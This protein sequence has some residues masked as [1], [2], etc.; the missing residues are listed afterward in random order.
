MMKHK[1]LQPFAFILALWLLLSSMPVSA[2]AELLELETQPMGDQTVYVLAEDTTKRSEFEKHYYC[3]DGTFVA[4]TY[5]EAVHYK[6]DNGEWIDVDMR[7]AS[8]ASAA[9]YEGQSGDFKTVFS[10]PCTGGD[11][12]VMA[13]GVSAVTPAVSM[14][15]GEYTLSWSLTGT[16]AAASAGTSTYALNPAA[17]GGETI[18]SASADTQIQV[19]GEMKTAEPAL[20]VQKIP[21]TDPDAFAL[22]SASN[23][24]LYENIFGEDQ[25][26]S[27][28]YSVTQNRIEED[29]L[30]TAPTDM[31]S[32]SMQVECTGL[33]PVLNLD[34]SVDF[35]DNNGEMV[36]HVS[37]PYLADAAFSVSYDVQVTL[38]EQDGVCTITYTPDAEWMN[39]PEREYPIMLDPAVTTQNY[40]YAISDTH[41]VEGD[42]TWYYT[43]QYLDINQSA[44]VRKA[45]IFRFNDLPQIEPG[46]PIHSATFKLSSYTTLSPI[47]LKLDSLIQG[48]DMLMDN[49]DDWNMMLKNRI[50]TVTFP[51]GTSTFTFDISTCITDMYDGVIGREFSVALADPYSTSYVAPIFS[52]DSNWGNS[53]KPCLIIEYGYELTDNLLVGDDILIQNASSDGYLCPN[54]GLIGDGNLVLHAPATI[55]SQNRRFTLKHNTVTGGYQFEYNLYT[56]NSGVCVSADALTNYVQM[57][58][59]TNVPTNV[60]REWLIIPVGTS[61]FKIALAS[62]TRYVMT[63]VGEKTDYIA[64]PDSATGGYVSI[65]KCTGTPTEAQLWHI[66]KNGSLVYNHAKEILVDNGTYYLN[67]DDTGMFLRSSGSQ[68]DTTRGRVDGLGI[69]IAWRITWINGDFYILQNP[70][71]TTQALT[72]NRLGGVSMTP[73]GTT[74]SD[75]QKWIFSKTAY[76][77]VLI[78]EGT[79]RTLKIG[80]GTDDWDLVKCTEYVEL[81]ANIA[82]EDHIIALGETGTANTAQPIPNNTTYAL[83]NKNFTYTSLNPNVVIVDQNTG[84]FQGVNRGTAQ[85]TAMHEVTGITKT[86]NVTVEKKAIIIVPGFAGSVLQMGNLHPYYPVVSRYNNNNLNN[87]KSMDVFSMQRLI[88][89]GN[90]GEEAKVAFKEI[91]SLLENIST[92]YDVEA[93]INQYVD[94]DSTQMYIDAIESMVLLTTLKMFHD[95]NFS[96]HLNPKP[97]NLLE[98]EDSMDKYGVGNVYKDLYGELKRITETNEE[99]RYYEVTLFTYDWRQSCANSAN[100]LN[101]FIETNA[102]DNVILVCHS[103]GGLVGDGYLSIGE[104]QREKVEKY[105]TFGTPH[106]GTTLT[107]AVCLTG[108]VDAFI[109]GP[110]DENGNQ[111]FWLNLGDYLLKQTLVRWLVAK[112]PSIY[113]LM[114]T[115]QYVIASGGYIMNKDTKDFLSYEE[116]KNMI[117]ACMPGY[118]STLMEA[119]EDFH[120]SLYLPNTVHVVSYVDRSYFVYSV[121]IDSVDIITF[122]DGPLLVYGDIDYSVDKTGDSVVPGISATMNYGSFSFL[123]PVQHDHMNM[124]YK[125]NNNDLERILGNIF[126]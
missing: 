16:K 42:D 118:E 23:Q 66:Y 124:I 11:A 114:P 19:L 28:R 94:E 15:S 6:D 12:S 63:A 113:E 111:S 108:D 62:D 123:E 82:F 68:V 87:A 2:F 126:V 3:S 49:Y 84:E 71:D 40:D 8:D 56:D 50:D 9:S 75:A 76:G 119:A 47:V 36:Y 60:S 98:S 67:Q 103:T 78:N 97:F 32:F 81:N 64:N 85:I 80:N 122:E 38:T 29:F 86:F 30:I 104:S 73:I 18:M 72:D 70:A 48:F 43:N 4:V 65:T 21:V 116:T 1:V 39:A 99:Y 100:M 125:N 121:D 25:N 61:T 106:W 44:G 112:F 10:T 90:G 69:S 120:D 22:P 26:V 27:V 102:Y 55:P 110:D 74:Y 59:S 57:Q 33:T 107:P 89:M 46:M 58:G 41:V 52:M 51:T 34:N 54:S 53:L 115:E 77:Y 35:L 92:S 95:Y 24:I 79:H 101:S 45:A 7:L 14:Q 109:E 20:S 105:I 83:L 37:T 88:M 93:A 96:F 5:P 31:T 13:N 17:D 91:L 117:A